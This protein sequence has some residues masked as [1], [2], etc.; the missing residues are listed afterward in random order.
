MRPN[1]FIFIGY[2]KMGGVEGVRVSPLNP[3]WIRH[4]WMKI[5]IFYISVLNICYGYSTV[6]LRGFLCFVSEIRKLIFKHTLL[7]GGLHVYC[8]IF[9]LLSG[10]IFWPT[11]YILHSFKQCLLHHVFDRIHFLANALHFTF[12]Q[13]YLLFDSVYFVNNTFPFYPSSI[14]VI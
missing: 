9:L 10:H 2:L 4:C 12:L 7:S 11:H 13:Q 14:F 3:L 5:V 1:Y 8:S 6:S